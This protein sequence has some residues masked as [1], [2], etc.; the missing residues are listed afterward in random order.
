MK[1]IACLAM[2]LAVAACGETATEEPAAEE[3]VAT[4]AAPTEAVA[5]A[6]DGK[7]SHGTF[8]ATSA[9][10][11]VSTVVVNQ[12]GTFT[13]TGA[14]GQTASGTWTEATPGQFCETIDGTETCYTEA[15]VDGKWTSTDPEGNVSTIER[16][17]S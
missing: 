7:P 10:G 16:V 14:D 1:K 12:D 13:A 2:L 8:R 11:S 5:T 15:L 6:L 4:E 9:D 17:E 3:T